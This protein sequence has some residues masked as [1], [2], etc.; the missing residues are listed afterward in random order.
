M[1]DTIYNNLLPIML[2][3]HNSDDSKDYFADLIEPMPSDILKSPLTKFTSMEDI[4]TVKLRNY[5]AT[6]ISGHH[7]GGTCK[8]GLPNDPMAV[9]DSHGRVF[10]IESL[11]IAD[12]SILP[13]S[14]RWP[15]MNLYP[16][17]EK[18]AQHIKDENKSCRGSIEIIIKYA[19]E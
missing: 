19:K 18:I 1:Y 15:G 16:L 9:V 2:S 11:R 5:I 10:G 17:G 3:L 7:A 4:D 6:H 8:M 13:V 14:M 12:I